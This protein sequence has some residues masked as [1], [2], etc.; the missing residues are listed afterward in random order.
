SYNFDT[1]APCSNS[2]VH[3]TVPWILLR[4]TQFCTVR[5]DCIITLLK[6]VD[7][8]VIFCRITVKRMS[9]DTLR[10]CK[11][12][13]CILNR[14]DADLISVS[15]CIIYDL[16]RLCGRLSNDLICLRICLLHDLMFTDKL[17]CLHLC[18]L[19]HSV[20]LCLCICK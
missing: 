5:A 8:A 4:D 20:R 12:I 6:G 17:C 13:V 16:L 9:D 18:L 1:K 19:D 11:Q 14:S 3:W 2:S 7:K 15:G 10:V